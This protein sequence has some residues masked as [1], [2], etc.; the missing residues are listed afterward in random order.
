MKMP[1]RGMGL[2]ERM[3]KIEGTFEQIDKRLGRLEAEVHFL[4]EEMASLREEFRNE[5][6]AVRGEMSSF[7]EEVYREIGS[8]RADMKALYRMTISVLIPMWV[9][10][11]GAIIGIALTK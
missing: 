11:I 9:T 7:R 3:A 6:A 5:I 4:R 1:R 2:E 10:I 8:L